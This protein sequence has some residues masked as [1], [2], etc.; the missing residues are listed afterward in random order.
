MNIFVSTTFAKDGSAASTVC[1][2]LNASGIYNIEIGSTHCREDLSDFG[3]R[4]GRFVVHNFFPIPD[5][6]NFVVNL[7]AENERTRLLALQHVSRSLDF[8]KY[9]GAEYYTIHPGF[10]GEVVKPEI[11]IQDLQKRNFDFVISDASTDLS[12]S[13]KKLCEHLFFR[14]VE[15]VLNTLDHNSPRVLVETEGSLQN[16][17]RLLLQTPSEIDRFI[18]AFKTEKIGINFNVAHSYFSSRVFGIPM[19]EIIDSCGDRI[20]AVEISDNDGSGDQH[21]PLGDEG[22]WV[23]PLERIRGSG[24]SPIYIIEAR[25]CSIAEVEQSIGRLKLHL[26]ASNV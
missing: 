11:S 23:A 14:S 1:D 15:K 2:E 16:H 3:K 19:N 24:S 26:A 21:L 25:N 4:P 13:A 12:P 17:A 8:C 18:S 9:I 22:Y 5:D 10:L 7:G 20:M 6:E